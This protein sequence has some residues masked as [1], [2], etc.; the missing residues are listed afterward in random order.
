MNRRRLVTEGLTLCI[1]AS[2]LAGFISI[3]SIIGQPWTAIV[4]FLYGLMGAGWAFAVG[5]E[6]R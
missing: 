4:I 2:F 3:A 1:L 5:R 6:S